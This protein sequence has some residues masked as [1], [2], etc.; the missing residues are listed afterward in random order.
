MDLA[1]FALG[2]GKSLVHFKTH[3][4]ETG[5]KEETLEA[6]ITTLASKDVAK[7][8]PLHRRQLLSMLLL[9]LCGS[10]GSPK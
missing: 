4:D 5:S 10:L 1:K 6:R 8:E 9:M 2:V 3:A 7:P